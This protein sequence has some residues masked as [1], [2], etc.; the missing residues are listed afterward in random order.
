MQEWY[1]VY[2]LESVLQPGN[3][4]TGQT[5]NLTSR[6]AKH[7]EGGCPHTA[8]LRPWRIKNFF[9][10]DSKQKAISF[11]KYLKSGSG[12]EFARRHF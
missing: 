1:Y 11:E 4:Y 3:Y 2:I 8:K 7:N 6:L 10:F 5:S 12:R 9:A